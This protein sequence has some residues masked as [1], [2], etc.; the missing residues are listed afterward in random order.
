MQSNK[1]IIQ[2]CFANILGNVQPGPSGRLLNPARVSN[3]ALSAYKQ[4]KNRRQ[5]ADR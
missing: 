4:D 3:V 2:R 1:I 5:H